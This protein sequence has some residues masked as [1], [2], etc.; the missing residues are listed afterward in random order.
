ARTNSRFGC[1]TGPRNTTR[2]GFGP[3]ALPKRLFASGANEGFSMLPCQKKK[4]ASRANEGF[5]ML[6]CQKRL[7]ASGA[8]VGFYNNIL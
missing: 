8:N 6:P 1:V 7:F 3:R 4:I 2:Y 5:S